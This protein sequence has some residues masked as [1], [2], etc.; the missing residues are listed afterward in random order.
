MQTLIGRTTI[1]TGGNQGLGKAIAQ[2]FIVAGSHVVI[3]ARDET[4][5][6]STCKEFEHLLSTDQRLTF[7]TADIS[8]ESDVNKLVEKVLEEHGNVDVLVNNAGVYGPKGCLEENDWLEWKR[9][10]EINL[11]GPA[12]LCRTLVPHFK[13]RRYGKIINLSGGGA[14]APLPRLTSYA[15]AKAALVRLTETLAHEC[16]DFNID[17]NAVAPGP[18]NTR[19]LDEILDAGPD[20]VGQTFFERAVK[21]KNDGGASMSKAADLCVFLASAASDGITGRLLSAIWDPWQKISAHLEKLQE[22]DIYTLR[23]IL[24]SDRG[25]NWDA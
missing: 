3:C 4:L 5:L 13:K 6:R 22:S 11:F 15:V 17:V 1:V 12:F 8:R 23:R 9:S 14:T 18:L 21:Q 16:A 19:L 7:H 2:A 25:E 24:P 10:I 20:K